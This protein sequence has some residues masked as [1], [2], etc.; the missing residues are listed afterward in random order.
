MTDAVASVGLAQWSAAVSDNSITSLMAVVVLLLA[1]AIETRVRHARP[2]SSQD[3]WFN[4]AYAVVLLAL[5]AVLK[6]FAMIVPLALTNALGGGWISFPAGAAGRF[7]AFLVVLVTTDLLE[8][9]FH[10]AQHTVPILWRMHELHHSAEHFDVTLAYRHFWVEPLLKMVFVYPLIGLLFKVAPS[11]ALAMAVTVQ[12]FQYVAHMN[13]RFSPRRFRLL[14]THPQY[15]R[16]HHST[17]ARDYNNNLCALLPLWDI[18]FGTLR[19]PEPDEFVDVGL[20]SCAAPRKLWQALLWPWRPFGKPA[21]A[22]QVLAAPT[23]YNTVAKS[24]LENG[25]NAIALR[26]FEK[27][28]VLSPVYLPQTQRNAAIER[29]RLDSTS[30]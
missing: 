26:Y 6:P 12:V 10:R 30:H 22:L 15:H 21:D 20:V 17:A 9:W 3:T 2:P 5:I 23:A 28:S 1:V 16:V 11:V 4:V 27:A 8:Y 18:L 24:A 25:D 14:V 29:E 13:L 7:G 19:R